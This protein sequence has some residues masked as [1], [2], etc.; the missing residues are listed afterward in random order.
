MR[1]VDCG[2]ANEIDFFMTVLAPALAKKTPPF[3]TC[4][5]YGNGGNLPFEADPT[6]VNRE[7]S[8]A[9]SSASRMIAL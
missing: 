2:T 5:M 9:A 4:F 3:T 8:Y 1:C 7:Y 6:C